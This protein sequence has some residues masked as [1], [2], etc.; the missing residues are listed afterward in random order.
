MIGVIALNAGANGVGERV[1]TWC[2]GAH[3]AESCCE[4]TLCVPC[5]PQCP[6][7]P[8]VRRRTPEERAVDA[9]E[10]RERQMFVRVAA[11]RAELMTIV[12]GINDIVAE[13]E[14]HTSQLIDIA[15]IADEAGGVQADLDVLAAGVSRFAKL[16]LDPPSWPS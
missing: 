10:V 2:C 4:G 5:C 12:A 15:A 8:V 3:R 9:A 16:D 7:C 6:T 1:I 14:R 13:L 11:H